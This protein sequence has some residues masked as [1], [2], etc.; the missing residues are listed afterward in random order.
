MSQ[1]QPSLPPHAIAVV[2]ASYSL[3]GGSRHLDDLWAG[4]TMGSDLVTQITKDRFPA[5][6]F[7]DDQQRRLG[8]SYIM[9]GGFLDDIVGLADWDK[10]ARILPA[11]RA[12]RIGARFGDVDSPYD[13]A[14][15][16][17]SRKRYAEA[18]DDAEWTAPISDSLTDVTAA[19][20][21]TLPECVDRTANLGDLR[22][23]SRDFGCDK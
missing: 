22:M 23:G 1:S 15:G 7:T 16:D 17:D 13:R 11:I 18:A 4:W 3:P 20:L 6:D 2:G 10:L 5:E 8:R 19:V 21:Q 9:V 14:N 12:P